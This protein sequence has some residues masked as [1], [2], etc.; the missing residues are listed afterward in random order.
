MRLTY[1]IDAFAVV[2]L[3]AFLAEMNGRLQ[4]AGGDGRWN[5]CK[6]V[7][8]FGRSRRVPPLCTDAVN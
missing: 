7:L 5:V 1:R 8:K 6:W 2:V 4:L 3:E